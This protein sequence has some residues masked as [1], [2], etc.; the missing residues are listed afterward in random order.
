MNDRVWK[1]FRD[2]RVYMLLRTEQFV[3]RE[4]VVCIDHTG[5]RGARLKVLDA[6]VYPWTFTEMNKYG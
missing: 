4:G 1:Y 3:T 6:R 2:H 5:K